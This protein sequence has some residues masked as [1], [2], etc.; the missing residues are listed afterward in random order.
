[1]SDI[2]E[3]IRISPIPS[4]NMIY[5]IKDDPYLQV[6]NQEPSMSSKFP[7]YLSQLNCVQYWSNCQDISILSNNIFDVKDDHILQVSSQ[8]PSMSSKFHNILSQDKSC[9]ISSKLSG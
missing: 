5:E 7:T 1:M 4:N 6:S 8:E 9:L 2:D 3:T